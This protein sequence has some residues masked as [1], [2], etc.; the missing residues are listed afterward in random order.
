MDTHSNKCPLHP[1]PVKALGAA[2][3]GEYAGTY[4]SEELLDALYTVSVNEDQLS[5]KM[6]TIE[7]APL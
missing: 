5:V 6:R 1:A 7:S 3:L 4:V 2:E